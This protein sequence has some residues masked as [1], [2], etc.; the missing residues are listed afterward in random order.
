MKK[1]LAIILILSLYMINIFAEGPVAPGMSGSH[2]LRGE[3]NKAIVMFVDEND[4][5]I[6]G[7]P[8]RI[9]DNIEV[10][11]FVQEGRTLVPIRFI[12]ERLDGTVSWDSE[13]QKIGIKIGEDVFLFQIGSDIVSVNDKPVKIET[14]PQ[15]LNG[16]SFVPLRV[17]A[18]NIGKNLYYRNKVI[19]ISNEKTVFEALNEAEQDKIIASLRDKTYFDS[20]EILEALEDE[21]L[22]SGNIALSEHGILKKGNLLKADSNNS[23]Y[24]NEFYEKIEKDNIEMV[25]V[26]GSYFL[27]SNNNL[28]WFN[29]GEKSY[30]LTDFGYQTGRKMVLGYELEKENILSFS[31]DKLN[32]ITLSKN[33]EVEVSRKREYNPIDDEHIK[34]NNRSQYVKRTVYDDLTNVKSVF[35]YDDVCFVIKNDG[36][37]WGWGKNASGQLGSGTQK[38]SSNPIK[39]EGIENP[40]YITGRVSHTICLT[41]DGSLYEWGLNY[42]AEWGESPT[43]ILTPK[44]I[45]GISDVIHVVTNE[46]STLAVKKDGTVWGIG[47]NS[48]SQLGDASGKKVKE[49]TQIGGLENILYVDMQMKDRLHS[50]LA[51]SKNGELYEWGVVRKTE[52]T[53]PVVIEKDLNIIYK[54]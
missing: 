34:R 8:S 28:Y 13:A 20:P 38:D 14:A 21:P 25:S 43:N 26:G 19:V 35:T 29:L 50:S 15:L 2:I 33:G 44:K 18:D 27:D 16:R 36:S 12:I 10:V 4:V 1:L 49:F 30:A 6:N 17:I 32:I 39:I 48:K 52:T 5:F 9:D 45:E 51:V 41:E 40:K 37:L 53:K 42:T 23:Y 3:L 11:P 46:N 47:D 31:A 7:E 24:S 22:F 54:Y